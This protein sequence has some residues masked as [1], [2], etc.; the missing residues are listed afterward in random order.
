MPRPHRLSMVIVVTALLLPITFAYGK[1]TLYLGGAPWPPYFYLQDSNRPGGTDYLLLQTI[2]ARMDYQLLPEILPE[3]RVTRGVNQG[4]IDVVLG[5]A[6]TPE[7]AKNNYYSIPYRT[8][9][10]GYGYLDGKSFPVV[11]KDLITRLKEGNTL[12]L[13]TSGWF[14]DDFFYHLAQPYQSQLVHIDSVA[15]RLEFL[16]LGRV[17]LILDDTEVLAYNALKQGID[18]TISEEVIQHQ[19]IYFMFSRFSVDQDFMREF[20]RLLAEHLQNAQPS[21]YQ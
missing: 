12:A 20:N 18:L 15:R 17:D 13:N 14:G 16:A 7:R 2:L 11:E 1:D 19:K 8:E 6:Y 4:K 10:V 5:A 9:T 21:H 3:K